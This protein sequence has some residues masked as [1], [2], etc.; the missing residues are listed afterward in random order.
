MIGHTVVSGPTTPFHNHYWLQ[1]ASVPGIFWLHFCTLDEDVEMPC[2]YLHIVNGQ[3]Q[4]LEC[5][6]CKLTECSSVQDMF[7]AYHF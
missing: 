5:I 4:G 7:T 6:N 3:T 1:T 2:Q